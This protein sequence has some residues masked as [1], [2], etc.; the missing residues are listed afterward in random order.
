MSVVSSRVS[1]VSSILKTPGVRSQLI[2]Q[3]N[4]V[5]F[6]LP[7]NLKS[8]IYN[9]E[10][11]N[12]IK[13]YEDLICILRDSNIKD[14]DLIEFLVNV[15]QCMSLLG[16]THQVF[17][18]TLLQLKWTNRSVEATSAYKAFIEDLI[19]MQIYYAKNVIDNLVEQFKPDENSDT[20][21]EAGQCKEEDVQRLNHIHDILCKILKIVPMSSKLLL[22]SLRARFPYIVH[23]THTHEVYVYALIQI[24]EY[25]PQLR[26]DILSLIINRL[27]VLD[28]NIPR[29]ET[30]NDDE[31]LMDDSDCDSTF[32]NE[33]NV[34]EHND[35]T[36]TDK[37][38]PIAHKLDVCMTLIL[39]YMHNSCLVEGV[40]QMESL[41]SLYFDILQIFETVILPTHASQFVQYII[42]YICSFKTAVA[43]AFIDWLWRKVSD[44]NIPSITR[45]SSVAYIA[46]FL[47]T[48]NFITAGLVKAVQFRL[49]KWIHDYI[50][51]QD[52]SNYIDDENK[53]HT[54]FYSVCQALFLIITKRHNDF[55]DS[56][57]YMLYLQE[58]D[59]AKIITCKLNPLKACHPEIVHNF[60]EITRMY[61]LAYCYTIIENNTRSQLPIFGSKK[62]ATITVGNFFPFSSYTLAQSG[63]Q[64][65]SLFR[66]NV[67]SSNEHK[68]TIKYKEDIEYMT[69]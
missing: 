66:D 25:A 63:Q 1:S 5:Y 44:P 12:G 21:W 43:E 39:K 14:T 67:T 53:E 41:K 15:R 10:T 47:V 54:V 61:Q 13:D 20:E 37:I 58:L 11:G 51:M 3:S 32:G 35:T 29:L 18:E 24:L 8:I 55:P 45:Q 50:N 56:K 9:F 2:R 16:P 69:E 65:I 6:K 46:S 42:F 60:A 4:R 49:C 28:V 19:C 17:I 31:D 22:Q 64:L 30:D 27:M 68:A 26:S 62:A 48:A 38:H 40:L 33:N 23:G 57:K 36:E 59:L 52:H 7:K 34:V